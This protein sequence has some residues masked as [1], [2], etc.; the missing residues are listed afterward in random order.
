MTRYLWYIEDFSLYYRWIWS[1]SVRTIIFWAQYIL[2]Y[3]MGLIMVMMKNW[4]CWALLNRYVQEQGGQNIWTGNGCNE[5]NAS[6]VYHLLRI[7]KVSFPRFIREN[8][9]GLFCLYKTTR[10]SS[11]LFIVFGKE[12]E[13]LQRV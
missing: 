6:F 9:F 4:K 3:K 5:T 8:E 10:V 11:L 2:K 12:E 13:S 7:Q 1:A